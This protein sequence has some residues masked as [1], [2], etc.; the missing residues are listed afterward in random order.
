MTDKKDNIVKIPI[1][2]PTSDSD[3]LPKEPLNKEEIAE[4]LHEEELKEEN[5]PAEVIDEKDEK[6][7]ELEETVKRLYADFDNFR[8]RKEEE[9]SE[10]RKR[11]V[12]RVVLEILPIMDNFERAILVSEES[13]NY[14]AL[15]EG[16]KM[17]HKQIYGLLIK[18][19]VKEIESEGKP[20]N[21]EEHQVMQCEVSPEHEEDTIIKELLKGYTLFDRV[22]RPSMV[23][24]ARNA[25]QE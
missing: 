16:L 6:I 19:G 13:E 14:A 18:E 9:V 15:K 2:I 24:V 7:K 17:V 4:A 5:L 1:N 10:S 21:P 12:E 11:A 20:F 8:R 22:I 3:N 25:T 23:I